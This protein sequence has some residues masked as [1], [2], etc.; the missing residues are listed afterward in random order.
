M[1]SLLPSVLW[2]GSASALDEESG[3]H[4]E[5]TPGTGMQHADGA[6][7]D[8]DTKLLPGC[9]GRSVPCEAVTSNEFLELTDPCSTKK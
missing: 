1:M 7:A 5:R 2:V 3:P 6:C 8:D 9:Q 4:S